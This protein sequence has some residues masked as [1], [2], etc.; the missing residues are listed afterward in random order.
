MLRYWNIL[1]SA[2]LGVTSVTAWSAPLFAEPVT[3]TLL[4]PIT[5]LIGADYIE[6]FFGFSARKGDLISGVLSYEFSI[7]PAATIRRAFDAHAA[8]R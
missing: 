5:H 1:R 2:I 8:Q 6:Q 7:P 4:A 3:C